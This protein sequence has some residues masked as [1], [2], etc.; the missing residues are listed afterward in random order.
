MTVQ[1]Q[2]GQLWHVAIAHGAAIDLAV[3]AVVKG[4]VVAI[5]QKFDGSYDQLRVWVRM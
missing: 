1:V 2:V 5:K 3:Q 4:E